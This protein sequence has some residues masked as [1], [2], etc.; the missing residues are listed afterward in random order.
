[1]SNK[2]C[3]AV[4][5]ELIFGRLDEDRIL[6]NEEF[7]GKAIRTKEHANPVYIVPGHNISIEKATELI[8]SV[9]NS[10]YKMPYPLHLAHKNL[11]KLKKNEETF[12]EKNAVEG[13]TEVEA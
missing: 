8:K 11:V 7:K 9:V 5:K 1:L 2:P 12:S 4:A 3:V 10:D 13:K 6:Y